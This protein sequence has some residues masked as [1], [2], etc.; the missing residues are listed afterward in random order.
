MDRGWYVRFVVVVGLVAAALLALW[1]S[2]HAWF[3]APAWV[4]EQFTGR[5]SPGLD[6]RG[7]LRLV[8]EV[9]VD[10][11]V[12][13]RRDREAD[14]LIRRVGVLL[15][16]IEEDEWDEVSREQL[17]EIRE[18]VQ[19]HRL[20]KQQIR[21]TFT[22]ASKVDVVERDWLREFFPDLREA[23]RNGNQLTL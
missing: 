5:I 1:P 15:E 11:A 18:Q 6:I 21:L 19:A 14:R 9:E 4:Q 20:G 17:E 16:L 22:D 13:Y 3:P 10:E 12:R 2:V 8:Y 7:G 23:S